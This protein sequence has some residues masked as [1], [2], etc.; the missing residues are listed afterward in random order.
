LN[1]FVPGHLD[2]LRVDSLGGGRGGRKKAGEFGDDP[3]VHVG[4]MEEADS[5][6]VQCL[7]K[8][9]VGLADGQLSSRI[10]TSDML[11]AFMSTPK[12]RI[13]KKHR[14]ENGRSQKVAEK[15]M[16]GR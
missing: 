14:K 13:L 2:G 10:V 15:R 3:F 11:A 16:A 7:G 12:K 9:F 6:R 8:K 4:W 5:E 1:F